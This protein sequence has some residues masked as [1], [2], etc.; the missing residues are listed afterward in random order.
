MFSTES[1]RDYNPVCT[2]DSPDE[3]TRAELVENVVEMKEKNAS[4]R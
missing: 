1:D 2:Y 3:T 4:V